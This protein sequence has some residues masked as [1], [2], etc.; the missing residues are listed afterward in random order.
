MV[1][2][3]AEERRALSPVVV[4]MGVSGVGKT[5]IGKA[6]ANRLHWSFV[7]GDDLH[8]ASNV[9]KMKRG[10]PLDDRDRRPWLSELHMVIED[11][12]ARGSPLVL[13]CS[14]LKVSYRQ[15]L[16][17]DLQAVV[18]VYLWAAPDIIATRLVQRRDHFMPPTLLASQLDALEPPVAAISVEV[19]RPV[20]ETV[21][22]IV[23][24]LDIRGTWGT[25]D[26]P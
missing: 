1:D 22:R 3:T 19:D 2:G 6:L 9:A 7:D 8:P 14:A 25:G 16:E 17:G 10:E 21:D 18:F 15:A 13:C 23:R 12:R 5:T 11:H 24:E 20:A 4:M 26:H